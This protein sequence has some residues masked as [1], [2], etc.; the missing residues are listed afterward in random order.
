MDRLKIPPNLK[1]RAKLIR[2]LKQHIEGRGL[3]QEKVSRE[4]GTNQARV[5]DIVRREISEFTIDALVNMADKIGMDWTF[6]PGTSVCSCESPDLRVGMRFREEQ[7]NE[8]RI[9]CLGCDRKGGFADDRKEAMSLW[10]EY[11]D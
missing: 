9:Q 4:L 6:G 7:D 5:S 11:I 1:V 8:V 10:L 3:T 2:L